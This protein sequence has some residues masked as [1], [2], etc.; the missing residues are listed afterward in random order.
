MSLKVL[1]L[2]VVSISN[3]G[4]RMH[5]YYVFATVHYHDLQPDQQQIKRH[6]ADRT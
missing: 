3:F 6:R 1:Y 2:D 5:I 4:P